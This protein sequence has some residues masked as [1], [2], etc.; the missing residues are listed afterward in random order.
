MVKRALACAVLL[1]GC[2]R[3]LGIDGDYV[4][5][6][7]ATATTGTG[8]GLECGEEVPP[9]AACPQAA[10]TGGC[11]AGVCVILCDGS[12]ECS[13]AAL[14]CPDGLACDV[15]CTG[16]RSC[17]NAVVDCPPEHTCAVSCSTGSCDG[18]D[19]A[20]DTGVC[21]FG[22]VDCPG[23][24]VTCGPRLCD[25]VCSGTP[26]TIDCADSCDCRNQ[27]CD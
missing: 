13:G 1:A 25:T 8:G 4:E 7:S 26:A 21:R 17:E 10:C 5:G 11:D 24:L 2:D 14:T 19:L 15:R 12:N 22:C 6:P 18:L 3:I 23:A 20:C 9:T 16:N 27:G